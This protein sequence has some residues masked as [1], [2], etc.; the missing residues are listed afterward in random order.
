MFI[1]FSLDNVCNSR[2]TRLSGGHR[3]A[4]GGSTLKAG[5]F[6]KVSVGI[7][8]S[9]LCEFQ[10]KFSMS[11]YQKKVNPKNIRQDPLPRNFFICFVDKFTCMLVDRC[12][13]YVL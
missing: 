13:K 7:S 2:Q 3:P 8:Q 12:T 9:V 10:R 4:G 1:V 11:Q 6:L 5:I